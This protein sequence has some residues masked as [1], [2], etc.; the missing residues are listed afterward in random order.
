MLN[1]EVYDRPG[2]SLNTH[3]LALLKCELRALAQECLGE[4]PNYQC[5]R[6]DGRDLDRL[7]I[8]VARNQEGHLMGFCSSYLFEV[9]EMQLLHLGLTCVSPKMRGKKLTHHLTSKVVFH[10]LW[11]YSFWKASWVSNVACVLSS[12]G[13]LAQYF[14]SVYPSPNTDLPPSPE[15]QCIAQ[16]LNSEAREE[17]FIRPEATFNDQHFVF[18]GSVL[19]NMFQKELQDR[20]YHHRNHQFNQFYQ[21]LMNFERGDEVLQVGKVSWLTFP[22]YYLKK[23]RWNGMTKAAAAFLRSKTQRT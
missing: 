9:E 22:K 5:L 15:Q 14:E 21:S 1:Y 4:L 7:I 6:S 11:H 13:N 19:G 20:R 3:D 2:A 23:F 16:Y 8:A 17:L 12:L 18:E 10:F